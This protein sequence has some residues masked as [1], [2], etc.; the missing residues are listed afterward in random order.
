MKIITTAQI[1]RWFLSPF[2]QLRLTAKPVST[3][4]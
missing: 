3:K 4:N 2:W 1:N